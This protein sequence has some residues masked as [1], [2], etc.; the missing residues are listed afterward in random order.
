MKSAVDCVREMFSQIETKD[1]EFLKI[2]ISNEI[3]KRNVKHLKI[4]DED[5]Y[6]IISVI[7][8]KSK[9]TAVK[10]IK[11]TYDVPLKIAKD[12]L[13]NVIQKY[14]VENGVL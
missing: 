9:L 2:C 10:Y 5:K 1:L 7:K 6:L 14:E 12:I 11:R 3:S 4:S 13:D 8:S